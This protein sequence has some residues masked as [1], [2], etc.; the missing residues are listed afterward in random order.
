MLDTKAF[1]VLDRLVHKD[2][3]AIRVWVFRAFGDTRVFRGMGLRD[4]MVLRDRKGRPVWAFRGFRVVLGRRG[5]KV[6]GFGATKAFR[7]PQE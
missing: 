4:L 2:C 5:P 3:E 1:R 7:G 6:K